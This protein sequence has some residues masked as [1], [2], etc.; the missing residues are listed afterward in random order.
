MRPST[1]Q[2][3]TQLSKSLQRL[4]RRDVI[5]GQALRPGCTTR[6]NH[7]HSPPSRSR[8]APSPATTW[9]DRRAQPALSLSKEPALS[10]SKEPA[11][12]LSK[13]RRESRSAAQIAAV[14]SRRGIDG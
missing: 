4:C 14:D 6:T 3:P 1:N 11:L 10:L 5:L 7:S 13:G 12:S 8:R 9:L 2:P